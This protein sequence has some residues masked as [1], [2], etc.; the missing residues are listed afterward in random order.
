VSVETGLFKSLVLSAFPKP[1]IAEVTLCNRSCKVGEFNGAFKSKAVCVAFETGL[2]KSLVLSTFPNP[3]IVEVGSVTVP[4]KTGLKVLLNSMHCV[5]FET[6]LF[7]SLVL[8]AFPNPTIAEVT[9]V[10]V[11]VKSYEF[12]GA[13]KIKTST[14]L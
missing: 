2:F 5:V 4:V 11:P 14:A 8:S 1:T 6:G 9:P 13:F 3:T 7:K 10:T 12:N